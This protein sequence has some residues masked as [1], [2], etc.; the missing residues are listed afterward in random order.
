[1]PCR[2]SNDVHERINE[3]PT[4]PTANPVNLQSGER[5][6]TR[7][8]EEKTPWSLTAAS[9]SVMVYHAEYRWERRSALPGAWSASGIPSLVNCNGNSAY[10]E[11][12]CWWAVWVGRPAG[13]G[14][15]SRPKVSLGETETRRKV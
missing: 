12:R 14:Y 9:A 5:A 15:P 6:G 10:A 13:K 4:V 1:M 8:W 7:Y 3:L 11:D 2:I